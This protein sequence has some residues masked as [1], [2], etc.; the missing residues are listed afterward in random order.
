MKVTIELTP[1]EIKEVLRTH[2]LTKFKEVGGID[3]V[4]KKEWV[5]Q[6]T[7]E[8]EVMVFKGAKCEIEI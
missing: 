6:Y 3:L 7:N 4:I 1:N 2:L 8:R 5:G